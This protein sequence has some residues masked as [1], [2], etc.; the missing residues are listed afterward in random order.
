M[1]DPC[2]TFGAPINFHTVL[3]SPRIACASA[4]ARRCLPRRARHRRPHALRRPHPADQHSAKHAP[5]GSAARSKR[6]EPLYREALEKGGLAP[7]EVLEG[8]VRLGSIRAALGKKDSGDRRVPCREH[9]RLDVRRADARPDRRAPT[10][11]GQGEEGH[12]E[13]SAA[14][15]SPS[16]CRRKRRPASRSRSRRR[17]TSAH[18]PDRRARSALV[19]RT[20]RR[21][22]EVTLEAK[23]DESVELEIAS[24]VTMPS[25]SILVRV[26]A[27]DTH[28][29]RLASA[30]ERVRVPEGGPPP[31]RSPARRTR[32]AP[33]RLV[34]ARRRRASARHTTSA[35][36]AA[37]GRRRGLTSS[38]VSRS[39]AQA[40]RSISEPA[41][42]PGLRRA[43]RGP[44]QVSS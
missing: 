29:N 6:A 39:R 27:L 28:S 1:S 44:S 26:D 43:S 9:P 22:K 8:Y 12:R 5:R 33:T 25:A 19:A 18:M 42:R 23:P 4:R 21:G 24:D 2:A 14:S 30:E 13:D 41:L 20:E 31:P 17:S 40:P 35:R 10:L 38:A 34:G 37:S 16:R 15:S 3:Q 36:A 11:R 32:A 7:N